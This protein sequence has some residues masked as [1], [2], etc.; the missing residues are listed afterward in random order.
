MHNLEDIGFNV[1]RSH[2]EGKFQ[3]CII[4]PVLIPRCAKAEPFS[5]AS[6]IGSG[7]NSLQGIQVNILENFQAEIDYEATGLYDEYFHL[8]A[9]RGRGV[10]SGSCS[11]HKTRTVSRLDGS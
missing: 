1:G 8:G 7:A 11:H 10:K 4:L 3:S 6:R 2:P 5:F 9:K